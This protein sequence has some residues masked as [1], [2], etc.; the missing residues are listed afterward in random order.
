V[1]GDVLTFHNDPQRLGWDSHERVLTHA[2]VSGGH[3]GKLWETQTDGQVYGEPLYV[4]GLK[5]A[6]HRVDAVIAAT[7]R[8]VVVALDAKTGREL[9]SS[10]M[11]AKPLNE[12]Q[13]DNCMNIRPWHGITSTPVIDRGSDTVYVCGITQPT[14]RQ[15]YLVWALDLVT[16]KVKQSWPVTLHGTYKGL[17]FEAGQLTQRGALNL[18]NGYLYIPF[19]SRCDIDEWHGW[20]IGLDVR[21]PEREP[22]A[23][24]P[25]LS[26]F[27]GGIWGSAGVAADRAGDL[28]CVTGNGGYNLDKGGDDVCES[29]LRLHPENDRL[30]FDRAKGYYVPK[31]YADLDNADADL[32]GSS[33]IVIPDL[34]GPTPH[35][36]LTGGKDGLVYM[37]NRDNLGGLGGELFKVR[38]FGSDNSDYFSDIKTTPAYFRKTG[39]HFV[40]FSG[41]LTGPSGKG[42]VIALEIVLGPKGTPVLKYTW[43]LPAALHQ[44]GAV[45]VSSNGENEPIVWVVES[46][47][48]DGDF[49]PPGVL[50]AIDATSGNVLY[51]SDS[52]GDHDLIVDARKFCCPTVADGRV[53]VGS[54]GVVAFGLLPSGGAK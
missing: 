27:G 24:S 47:K 29:I 4:S 18:V 21:H 32:G 25:C 3:F 26:V 41:N 5:T 39:R 9:W 13:Y 10:G 19:S 12:A 8:N 40:F 2:A 1:S 46:N 16:G 42:G 49:G 31:N 33:T 37:V 38:E 50:Y 36:T 6:G 53:Y 7:E 11:L 48:D 28:Y 22:R 52:N 44:P 30:S 45:T 34:P 54:R 51:R 17:K 20:V 43:G 14:L 23:F 15:V 35:V